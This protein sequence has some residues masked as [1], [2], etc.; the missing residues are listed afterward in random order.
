MSAAVFAFADDEA[1]AHRLAEQ[2]GAPLHRIHLH[3]F[4]DGESL[5]TVACGFETAILYRGLAGP[6]PKLFSL[7]LAADALRRGG[8]QRVVLTAPYLPYLRQDRV[9]APGQ[10]LSRD[11]LGALVGPAFDRIV[12]VA[13]HLHRTGDLSAVFAGTPVDVLPIGKL[14]AHAIRGP[15]TPLVVGP[16][17]ESHPW[18]S[19]VAEELGTGVLVLQKIRSGDAD[20]GLTIPEGVAVTGR[21]AVLVDDICSSGATLAAAAEALAVRGAAS[22]EA[23]VAHAL[24]DEAAAAGLRHAGIVR[25]SSTDSCRHPTNR[26]YLAGLLADALREELTA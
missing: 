7:L 6:D 20:V 15:P 21:R 18:A 19:A 1:P 22:V 24:F 23:I 5:P 13:P 25:I 14:F 9:F 17:A 2:L 11:L 12:T 10:P 3:R 16:D 4:P 8:A 26:I